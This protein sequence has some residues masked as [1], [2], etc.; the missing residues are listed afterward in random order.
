MESPLVPNINSFLR[1]RHHERITLDAS[2]KINDEEH[3]F[4]LVLDTRT[5][6]VNTQLDSP[7]LGHY[8][9]LAELEKLENVYLTNLK[10]QLL[11]HEI[12][13]TGNL[14]VNR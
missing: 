2:F 8:Q 9:V 6:T 5:Y 7:C 1:Y 12:G 13:L 4:K 11:T 14:T 3:L 10:A